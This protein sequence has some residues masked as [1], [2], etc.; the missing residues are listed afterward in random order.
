MDAFADT[1]TPDDIEQ[2]ASIR[3]FT[4]V[5]CAQGMGLG[6]SAENVVSQVFE[7]SPAARCAI[8][9]GDRL[10]SVDGALLDGCRV[11][12]IL[13]MTG[14]S[15]THVLRVQRGAPPPPP[16]Q[17]PPPQLP[18]QPLPSED[19]ATG[20][21]LATPP[22]P[23]LLPPPPEVEAE[24]EAETEQLHPLTTAEAAALESAPPELQQLVGRLQTQLQ[25][26]RSVCAADSAA[27]RGELGRLRA[28]VAAQVVASR[29][30][31]QAVATRD[32]SVATL[33]G[34]RDAARA[35]EEEQ[36]QAVLQA[37]EEMRRRETQRHD[38]QLTVERNLGRLLDEKARLLEEVEV[39]QAQK[40][41][42]TEM[43]VR[44]HQQLEEQALLAEEVLTWRG[45]HA[46]S[47]E[48]QQQQQAE[49]ARG[50]EREAAAVARS[51]ALAAER[52]EAR[53][54]LTIARDEAA[55]AQRAARR[56]QLREAEAEVHAKSAVQRILT[57]ELRA[58]EAM[59]ADADEARGAARRA[60]A[61]AAAAAAETCSA[62]A[63]A[64]AAAE[65]AA[66]RLRDRTAA[67]AVLEG[68]R[69]EAAAALTLTK[70]EAAAALCEAREVAA[71]LVAERNAAADE[72]KAQRRVADSLKLELKKAMSRQASLVNLS[73]LAG[74]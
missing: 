14:A 66:C 62:E 29:G 12:D 6:L 33:Q 47:V 73:T 21:V 72:A 19:A 61:A 63:E 68:V 51:A 9:V 43:L 48:A 49:G 32:E 60:A 39:L 55:A 53:Q 36:R 22:P 30:L 56:V 57:S 50:L 24:A 2:S 1:S 54:A 25:T 13:A 58:A 8:R 31:G 28:A 35:G 59:L 16:P 71:A 69:A 74:A 52:D 70:A 18:Q 11:E 3:D 17:P 5:G 64:G 44:S 4:L 42:V 37:E 38:D 27:Q 15:E 67:A 46:R 34:E 65:H 20:E 10:L 26:E 45:E 7:N 41:A 40:D 23:P